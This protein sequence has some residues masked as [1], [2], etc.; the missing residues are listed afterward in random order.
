MRRRT[1]GSVFKRPPRPGFYVRFRHRG[2]EV[3]R[4]AGFTR[5]A[6]NKK[7]ARAHALLADGQPLEEVL[8]D[9]F[10]DFTGARLTFKDAIPSYLEFARTRKRASTLAR[11]TRRFK[12][13]R[14]CPWAKEFLADVTPK[15]LTRF[16]SDRIEAGA[17]GATVNRD[18]L[19]ISALFKWAQIMGYVDANPARRVRKFREEREERVYLMAA[20]SRALVE[21]AAEDFRPVLLCALHTG[22]RKGEILSLC[23]DCVD[24]DQGT[25]TVR[26]VHEKAGRGRFVPLT[27]TLTGALSELRTG[28]KV[29]SMH[30]RDPV[31]TQADGTPWTVHSV[32]TAF[33]KAVKDCEAIPT[34]KRDKVTFHTLR[35]TAA[36]LM[37]A[38]GVPLYDVGK[39]LG[40]SSP[41]VTMQYAHFAPES[42]GRVAVTALQRALEASD[43][44]TGTAR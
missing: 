11:D 15:Q 32:R 24:L 6:A 37:V 40:Q 42:A 12:H 21:A 14:K 23:W 8:G 43:A 19:L 18:L 34:G 4:H 3:V 10:G 16:A 26:A 41:S 17:S 27:P 20:E 31:F 22:M 30:G 1:F 39:I 5:D 38:Q 13:L 9:V 7:L 35:H 29:L 44:A 33:D 28:R 2:R 36:S 25:L